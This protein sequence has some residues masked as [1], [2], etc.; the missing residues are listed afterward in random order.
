MPESPR[1]RRLIPN[2]QEVHH[3][4]MKGMDRPLN[5]VER[6]R[7]RSH[8][9]ICDACTRFNAQMQLMRAAMRRFGQDD[10]LPG[11]PR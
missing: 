6:L 9:V 5:W 11:S 10:D 4:T 3:L 2:C 1:P 7:V 8:L